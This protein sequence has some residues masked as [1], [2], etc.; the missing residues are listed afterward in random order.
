MVSIQ[1][2]PKIG[3]IFVRLNCTK[4]QPIFKIILLSELGENLQYNT[5]TKDPTTPQVC[6][7]TTLRNVSVLKATIANK[8][9]VTI[10]F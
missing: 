3:T 2:G 6:R 7:Y 8:T 10:H 9:C 4:Y 1:G 5:T